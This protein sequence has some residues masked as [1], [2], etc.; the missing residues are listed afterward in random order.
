MHGEPGS[1]SIVCFCAYRQLRV[2]YM[3]MYVAARAAG[4]G[5]PTPSTK[6][7][8]QWRATPPEPQT[9][10]HSTCATELQIPRMSL[11]NNHI[12]LN[13]PI[14]L[15]YARIRLIHYKTS[16]ACSSIVDQVLWSMHCEPLAMVSNGEETA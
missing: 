13:W 8:S 6:A 11:A 9:V 4:K 2:E 15:Y 10:L 3:Y 7:I 1:E 5:V 12:K 16:A 14:V